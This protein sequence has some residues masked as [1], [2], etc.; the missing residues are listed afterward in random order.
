M[1]VHTVFAGNDDDSDT[2]SWFSFDSSNNSS[3]ERSFDSSATKNFM[4][5]ERPDGTYTR[6]RY[7]PPHKRMPKLDMGDEVVIKSSDPQKEDLP[8]NANK[9]YA[10]LLHRLGYS[11]TA[12]VT[13]YVTAQFPGMHVV[14]CGNENHPHAAAHAISDIAH[15]FALRRLPA[16]SRI[17]EI[18]GIPKHAKWF[19]EMQSKSTNP[20]HIT[21]LVDLYSPDDFLR[22]INK[23]GNRFSINE[24]NEVEEN[25]L[26][27][28]IRD[29]SPEVLQRFDV[30]VF[31]HTGYYHTFEDY[32]H[33]VKS[34]ETARIIITTLRHD[35]KEGSLNNS[36]QFYKSLPNAR[37]GQE[38]VQQTNVV[39]KGTY[40]HPNI[41]KQFFKSTN[42]ERRYR[43]PESDLGL[44]WEMTPDSEDHWT[45]Q[46]NSFKQSLLSKVVQT[47][48]DAAFNEAT[49]QD[50]KESAWVEKPRSA[51]IECL[52]DP[53]GHFVQLEIVNVELV[54]RL[55][56]YA[57][58]QSR[59]GKDGETLL[60]RLFQNAKT[61]VEPGTLFPGVEPM[62]CPPHLIADHVMS[63]FATD[64]ER[65][66]S[67]LS[68]IDSLREVCQQHAGALSGSRLKL[69]KKST[70]HDLLLVLREVGKIGLR[71]GVTV[72]SA[73]PGQ[74]TVSAM[75]A[76][77]G[78]M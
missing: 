40:C 55:R 23:W 76:I 41:F 43:K 75:K 16:G 31:H 69:N 65:E 5:N 37:L 73:G 29:L 57:A 68:T 6:S 44:T 2:S 12:G 24:N 21:C 54:N 70:L 67:T 28:H 13:R 63:A 48:W 74:S 72:V 30:F 46:M 1:S 78:M 17:L 45:I 62:S 18:G 42:S 22:C 19:N 36:E 58:G 10:K 32:M 66:F 27:G 60:N 33:I 34:N 56:V 25:Y 9:K 47:D 77:E 20:K 15:R 39:D 38:I 51:P 71:L 7:V 52:P 3:S 14:S 59:V 49:I 26:K 11:L 4:R 50:I 61:L 8:G 64:I 35:K 53:S